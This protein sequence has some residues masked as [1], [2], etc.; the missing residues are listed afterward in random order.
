ML[1]SFLQP[2]KRKAR[3]EHALV[4]IHELVPIHALLHSSSEGSEFL[5]DAIRMEDMSTTRCE[6]CIAAGS[7][8]KLL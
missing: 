8:E 4:S 1:F 3:E 7:P 2:T 5:D 6:E